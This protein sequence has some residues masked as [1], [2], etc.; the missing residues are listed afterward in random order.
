[1][2]F[3]CE[4]MMWAQQKSYILAD[5]SKVEFTFYSKNPDE[6]HK[7]SLGLGFSYNFI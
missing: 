6:I 5:S 2:N 7:M 3:V 4:S 1:M